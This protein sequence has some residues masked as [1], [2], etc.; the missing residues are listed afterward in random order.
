MWS[1]FF[2]ILAI[3]C[4][5]LEVR[6]SAWA[7]IMCFPLPTN[8]RIVKGLGVDR[9]TRFG[10]RCIPVYLS[11]SRWLHQIQFGLKILN[12]KLSPAKQIEVP[13]PIYDTSSWILRPIRLMWI[14][15]PVQCSVFQRSLA[16]NKHLKDK[17]FRTNT[18]IKYG[19]LWIYIL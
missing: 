3:L 8:I 13:D 9:K 17:L 18:V 7:Q 11:C 2:H 1:K 15:L 16:G 6:Q 12:S 5:R 4:K 19:S 14:E 10:W